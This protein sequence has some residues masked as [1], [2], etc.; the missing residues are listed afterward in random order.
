MRVHS[1]F[2][3]GATGEPNT[4]SNR[5]TLLGALTKSSFTNRSSQTFY[6]K[7]Q[8]VFGA[9]STNDAMSTQKLD[10]L[11]VTAVEIRTLLDAGNNTSVE[12]VKTYLAQISLHNHEG[13]RLNAVIST[14]PEGLLL[15]QVKELDRE[16]KTLGPR[17]RIHG[18]PILSKVGSVSA[19]ISSVD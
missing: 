2:W 19:L 4:L 15:T 13:A 17:S 8:F 5:R 6:I 1:E 14:A 12:F 9:L 18:V 10:V 16:R 3:A 11:R 7:R